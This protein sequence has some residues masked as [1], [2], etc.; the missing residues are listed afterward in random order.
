MKNDR[1][2]FDNK[3]ENSQ[4][5]IFWF[6]R[7]FLIA[8]GENYKFPVNLTVIGTVIELLQ[9]TAELHLQNFDYY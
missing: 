8:C 4:D 3:S 7:Y 9:K 6:Q 1:L 5:E 2:P